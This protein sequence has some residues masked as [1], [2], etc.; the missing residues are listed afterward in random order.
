M[1]LVEMQEKNLY[2]ENRDRKNNKN[3]LKISG[4]GGREK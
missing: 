1:F 4:Y 2:N 3:F